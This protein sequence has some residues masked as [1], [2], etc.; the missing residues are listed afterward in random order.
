MGSLLLDH[1]KKQAS[2]FLQEKYKNARLAFTDVTE[3]ELLVEEATNNDPC[4]LDARIM[5]RIAEASLE[6]DDYW[7]IVDILHNRLSSND[8]KRWRQSY[9]SL[10]L[11]GFL[12]T[13]G[14][15]EF[16]EEFQCDTDVIQELGTFKHIDEKGFNWG[17]SMQ[18]K[19]DEIL[20][21][22]GGGET[23][24]QARLKALKVTKEIQGFGGSM[25]YPSSSTPSTTTPSSSSSEASRFSSFLS[26]STTS[27]T[28][29]DIN[30][31]DK[32]QLYT[33]KKEVLGSNSQGG[34]HDEENPIFPAANK[35]SEGSHLWYSPRIQ[36]TGSLLDS[37]D[38][39]DEKKDGF[40]SGICSKLV[41]SSPSRGNLEKVG[42]R[43]V[44]DAGRMTK[45]RF[46][47][48]HSLWY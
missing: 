33:P 2:S 19:S 21:L 48:Q 8:W 30:E 37:E 14:P 3:A 39:E 17:I 45:K 31:L 25:G 44:S 36:E 35:N 29:N 10:V 20:K 7:R 12:L 11:L 40:M 32:H 38:E 43:S 22:L 28:W 42:F 46:D 5:T 9:K 4:S 27:P 41:G 6:I 24:K 1:I 34:I 18:K 26:C 15:E 16:A 13:H 23:L 47:R